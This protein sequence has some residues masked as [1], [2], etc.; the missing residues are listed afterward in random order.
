MSNQKEKEIKLILATLLADI[1]DPKEMYIFLDSFLKKNEYLALSKR[2]AI[3]KY[4]A[5]GFSYK[6]IHKDLSV[7]SS[8][9]SAM[10]NFKNEKILS[11][12]L[13]KFDVDD[14]SARITKKIFNIFK[15]K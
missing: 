10:T 13:E 12:I 1:K 5:K 7:S 14:W 9:I 15:F 4:L 11:K 8:T 2:I 6:K 3:L